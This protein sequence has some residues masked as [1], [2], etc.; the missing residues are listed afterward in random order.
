MRPIED[1]ILLMKS[2]GIDRVQNFP[3]PS[4][5]SKDQLVAGEKTLLALGALE[6]KDKG[7]KDD[8]SVITG[9]GRTMAAFPVGPRFAKML[10]LSFHHSLAEYMIL[11]VSALTV[12]VDI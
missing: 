12:Q 6:L 2:M 9:L 10:A 1:M 3:Y 5:P 8:T 4:P 7:I 11:L